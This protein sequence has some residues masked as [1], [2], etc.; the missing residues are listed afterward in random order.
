[1]DVGLYN[2]CVLCLL[3]SSKYWGLV[4]VDHGKIN[5]SPASERLLFFVVVDLSSFQKETF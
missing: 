1:M 2:C 5:N 3:A 4:L